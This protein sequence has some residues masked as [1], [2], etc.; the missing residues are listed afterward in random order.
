MKIVEPV[1]RPLV[2]VS[3][4]MPELDAWAVLA[5]LGGEASGFWARGERWIAYSGALLELSSPSEGVPAGDRYHGVRERAR[6]LAESFDSRDGWGGSD[7]PPPRLFGGFSFR[8]DHQSNGVWG[9]FPSAHFILPR[10]EVEG[11]PEGARV[12]LQEIS[13]SERGVDDLHER[14]HRQLEDLARELRTTSFTGGIPREGPVAPALT[15]HASDGRARWEEVVAEV[16]EAIGEGS[17]SKVVLARSRELT[18]LGAVGPLEAV[19]RLRRDYGRSHVFC[20]QP[21]PASAF[22]GA[23]PETLVALNR[24]RFRSTAVAGSVSRGRSREDDRE[25]GRSLLNS[26]KDRWEHSVTVEEMVRV[27]RPL[28][29]ELEVD[30]EPHLLRLPRIQHLETRLAGWASPETHVLDLVSALHPTPAVCGLP[31]DSALEFIHRREPVERGWYAGPVGWFDLKGDGVFAPALRSA[32]R[33]GG[34]WRLFAG[35]GLVQ[36][37]V[38]EGEWEETALKFQPM[39]RAL[40]VGTEG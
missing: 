26:S 39:L 31:R 38:P 23:A 27:L 30:P 25:R 32:V 15:S 7:L 4:P 19:Q 12:V 33:S 1:V 2:R 28:L 9:H 16:L 34:V 3:T 5:R 36:G 37:S 13:A 20:F 21:H 11:G 17:L 35:A 29:D 8:E 6:D 18:D 24:R 14:L 40:G 10:V 22:V